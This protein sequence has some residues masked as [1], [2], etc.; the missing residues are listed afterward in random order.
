[1]A[2]KSSVAARTEKAHKKSA[3]KIQKGEDR[4]R[5]G[6]PAREL[7]KWLVWRIKCGQ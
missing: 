4:L 6:G 7:D 2:G 5:M 3:P 1:M